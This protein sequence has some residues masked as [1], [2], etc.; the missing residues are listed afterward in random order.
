MF[1]EFFFINFCPP[2]HCLLRSIYGTV[3][4]LHYNERVIAKKVQRV[5]SVMKSKTSIWNDAIQTQTHSL[6]TLC[7]VDHNTQINGFCHAWS[8]T[9]IVDFSQIQPRMDPRWKHYRQ[10]RGH[11]FYNFSRPYTCLQQYLT[12]NQIHYKLFKFHVWKLLMMLRP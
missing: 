7:I 4:N 10:W 8:R 9:C 5:L 6:S 3:N 2:Q 1:W 11:S 12:C